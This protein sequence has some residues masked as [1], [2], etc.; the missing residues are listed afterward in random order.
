M[1]IPATMNNDARIMLT[2]PTGSSN[3][4]P[5]SRTPEIGMIKI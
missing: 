4:N 1:T 5:P 2:V 3:K